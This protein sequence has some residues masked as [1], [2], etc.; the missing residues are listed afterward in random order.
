MVRIV[1]MPSI[2]GW[3]SILSEFRELSFFGPCGPFFLKEAINL[4]QLSI[5]D[6]IVKTRDTGIGHLTKNYLRPIY[7]L[8]KKTSFRKVQ[9]LV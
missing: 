7:L 4:V 8:P 2:V 5:L 1:K 9:L 3:F 6:T